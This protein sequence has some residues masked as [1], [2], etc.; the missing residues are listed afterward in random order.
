MSWAAK[1]KQTLTGLM[2][3]RTPLSSSQW[4]ELQ[5][6]LLEGDL[7]PELAEEML[8]D[9]KA[10]LE[11][12]ANLERQWRTCGRSSHCPFAARPGIALG[13]SARGDPFRRR[14]R[15]RKDNLHCQ[16]GKFDERAR[17]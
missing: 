9:L 8:E 11:R 17:S 5:V 14:Q 13:R 1:L 3:R 7:G 2:A 12:D 16:I 15:Y 6:L 4:E 10:S